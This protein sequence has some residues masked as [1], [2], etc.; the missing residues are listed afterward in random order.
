MKG[1]IYQLSRGRENVIIIIY[2]LYD[3]GV[4]KTI[5]LWNQGCLGNFK[6]SIIDCAVAG[7]PDRV[8]YWRPNIHSF[9]YFDCGLDCSNDFLQVVG[10]MMGNKIQL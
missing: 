8:G 7:D 2:N 4:W 5:F 3:L 1:W 6:V 10:K 9:S